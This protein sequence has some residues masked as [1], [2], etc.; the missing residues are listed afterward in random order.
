MILNMKCQECGSDS[1]ELSV[2]VGR[3]GLVRFRVD[4]HEHGG[5][6]HYLPTTE[7]NRAVARYLEKQHAEPSC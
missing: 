7:I 6:S 1:I 3:D 4:C 5:F 2:Q